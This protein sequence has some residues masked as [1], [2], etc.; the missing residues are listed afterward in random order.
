[1]QVQGNFI[2]IME[3]TVIFLTKKKDMNI[4]V[5]TYQ[6]EMMNSLLTF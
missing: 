2:F 6:I 4:Y 3:K 1:M 5:W